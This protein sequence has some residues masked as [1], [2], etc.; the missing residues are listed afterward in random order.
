MPKISF[1]SPYDNSKSPYIQLLGLILARHDYSLQV[2]GFYP[3]LINATGAIKHPIVSCAMT[4]LE[5]APA[6]HTPLPMPSREITPPILATIEKALGRSKGNRF[7]FS[8]ERRE[9]PQ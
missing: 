9:V 6:W 3:S 8:T 7:R 5:Q 4:N 1:T 2:C